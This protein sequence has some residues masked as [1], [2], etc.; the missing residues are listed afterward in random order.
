MGL[1]PETKL[2]VA[3]ELR[4]K[5][6]RVYFALNVSSYLIAS[7]VILSNEIHTVKLNQKV[8]KKQRGGDERCPGSYIIISPFLDHIS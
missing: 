8:I 1:V 4:E 3:N 2:E 6:R 5:Y 7:F